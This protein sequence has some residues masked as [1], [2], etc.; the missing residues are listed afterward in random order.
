MN[1]IF[2]PA[3]KRGHIDHGW[4]DTY[5]SFS[6]ASWHDAAKVHFGALRVLNDDTITGGT[7]FGMHPHDNMEIVTVVLEGELEHKDSM[8]N[9]GVIH[10]NEVQ[11]MSAGT[12]IFHSEYNHNLD[13]KCSLFQLWIFP[14]KRSVTPRYD[15]RKYDPLERENTLRMLVSP[16]E[17]D[18]PGLK[19]YQQA[20]IYRA[21]LASGKSVKL[22]LH[23]EDH[24]AYILNVEGA[25]TAGG[26][27]LGRRDAA[28]VTGMDA[29]EITASQDSDMLV[30]EVPMKL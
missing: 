5:H 10:A 18:E 22:D 25:I 19:I 6:F 13:T 16:M 26:K 29:V 15:Q 8:G 14:N 23:T 24:G 12:G 30:I 1:T 21:A 20:W 9:T 7:G 11:V 27:Q 4:L 17:S 28:G 3:S 2:H